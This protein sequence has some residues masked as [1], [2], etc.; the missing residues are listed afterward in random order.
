MRGSTDTN[1]G[2]V[3]TVC[4]EMSILMRPVNSSSSEDP[5]LD[6]AYPSSRNSDGRVSSAS[7]EAA[8]E[9]DCVR[10]VHICI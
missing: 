8:A 3:E 10:S 9:D 4:V 7:L 5:V 2:R 6:P 1:N